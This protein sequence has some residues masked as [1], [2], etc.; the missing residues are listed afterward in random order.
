MPRWVSWVILGAIG[1]AVAASLVG[2]DFSRTVGVQQAGPT[3]VGVVR[4][5]VDSP[6]TAGRVG[7]LAPDFEW[8][9]AGGGTAT[10]A[11]LRG[12]TVIVNFWAT[13]CVPCRDEMPALERAAKADPSVV[14][15]A[16]DLLEEGEPVRAFFDS[17]GLRALRP[18]LDTD[19]TVARRYAV[20]SLPT[21]FFVAPDGMVRVVH[22]GGPMSSEVIAQ[23]IAKAR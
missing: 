22:V 10:L 21:T 2:G 11:S 16:V 8:N 15:L 13:W 6:D 1:L 14:V 17:L 3:G 4:R 19:G 18:L 7:S 5:V 9:V 23:G 12:K 20:F